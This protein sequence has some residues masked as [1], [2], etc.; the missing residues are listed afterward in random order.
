LTIA[1]PRI[2][3]P[4]QRVNQLGG[5]LDRLSLL[6]FK[7]R[8]TIRIQFLA[9][10]VLLLVLNACVTPYRPPDPA[11]TDN[12]SYFLLGSQRNN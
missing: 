3:N 5:A 7:M 10:L 2:L 1:N 9:P 8:S 11:F 12:L 4:E 6:R